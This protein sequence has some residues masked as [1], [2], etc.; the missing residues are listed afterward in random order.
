[1]KNIKREDSLAN[2]LE[3]GPAWMK[4]GGKGELMQTKKCMNREK[5]VLW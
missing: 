3:G 5:W 4:V 1:M 2:I